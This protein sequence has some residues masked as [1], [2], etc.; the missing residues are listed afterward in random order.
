MVQ[1]KDPK[2]R[3]AKRDTW[4]LAPLAYADLPAAIDRAREKLKDNPRFIA[5]L[6][7]RGRQRA[8]VYKMLVITGLRRGELASLTVSSLIL[9]DP[10]AFATLKAAD[11]KNRQA[12]E[13]PLRSDLAN[14]LREWLVEKLNTVSGPTVPMSGQPKVCRPICR[15]SMFLA[16]WLNRS[17]AIWP[18]RASRRSMTGDV[19]STCTHCGIRSARSCRLGEWLRER[20]KPQCGIHRS[21]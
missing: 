19:R 6:E 1:A 21:I 17:T 18:R 14:D 5:E 8:L 2:D 10:V 7:L 16:N 3:K 11:A 13:I 20:P 9:T 12:T 15:Y 4:T